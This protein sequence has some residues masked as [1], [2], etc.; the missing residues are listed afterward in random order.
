MNEQ[1]TDAENTIIKT[2]VTNVATAAKIDPR[3]VLAIVMQESNGCVRIKKTS[4]GEA[5]VINPGL[6][7]SFNGVGTCN[8][9]DTKE[10]NP[11]GSSQITQMLIDGAQG[12]LQSGLPTGGLVQH[13]NAVGGDTSGQNYFKAARVYN[14][15]SVAAD[16]LLETAGQ[17]GPPR[18]FGVPCYS[19]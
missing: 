3:F 11:C 14:S 13:I 8:I 16:G 12:T 6:M 9:D 19:R 17:C 15:G 1:N 10:V 4:S 18:S 2:A 5:G 7:Q